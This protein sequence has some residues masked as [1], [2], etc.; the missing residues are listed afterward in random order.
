MV[1]SSDRDRGIDLQKK[2]EKKTRMKNNSPQNNVKRE[3]MHMHGDV[4]RTSWRLRRSMSERTVK[5]ESR[6][7]PRFP[8]AS[9]CRRGTEARGPTDGLSGHGGDAAADAV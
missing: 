7:T 8:V 1:S 3:T 4:A 5:K 2:K 6:T 9:G